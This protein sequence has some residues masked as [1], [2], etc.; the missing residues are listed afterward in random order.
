MAK[1]G[2]LSATTRTQCVNA[3]GLLAFITGDVQTNGGSVMDLM[4]TIFSGSFYKGNGVPPSI[5][6]LTAALHANALLTWALLV[7]VQP[8]SY[9]L[10]L[11]EKL[12]KRIIELLDSSSVDLRIAAGEVLAVLHEVLRDQ[13]ENFEV[14]GHDDLVEKL[15]SLATDSQKFRAKKDR[16]VQ[17]SSFR[18]ILKAVE[19][20]DSP[21]I[22]VK[23]GRERLKLD[24]WCSK[25]QYDAF[26][27]MLGSGMNRHLTENDLLRDIFSM[28]APLAFGEKGTS[29]V[30]KFQRNQENIAVCKARTK[31]LSKLR[32]KRADVVQLD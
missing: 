3:L 4:F 14:E 23:F 2:A 12:F 17:R 20:G 16:R 31:G 18:D 15:R 21:S 28:G 25:R 24:S 9:I 27:H 19:Q 7:T 13:D 5:N 1:D 29:K 6:P 30:S 26:C 10:G 11:T 32:D 22:V 8:T